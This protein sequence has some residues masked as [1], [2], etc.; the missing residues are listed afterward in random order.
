MSFSV[1]MVLFK[2]NDGCYG[3]SDLRENTIDNDFPVLKAT[4]HVSAQVLMELKSTHICWSASI[5]GTDKPLLGV[6][7]QLNL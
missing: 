5:R 1:S 2:S 6:F 3:R 7:K 4:K